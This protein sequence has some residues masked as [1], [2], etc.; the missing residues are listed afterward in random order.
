MAYPFTIYRLDTG[1]IIRTGTCSMY[2]D[3]VAQPISEGEICLD[4]Q[5]NAATQ[6]IV[7]GAA[8]DRPAVVEK[9]FWS[10]PD[11]AES[12][13][14]PVP[15]GT[16]VRYDGGEAVVDD[17]AFEFGSDVPG[18]FLFVIEPPFPYQRQELRVSV[19]EV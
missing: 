7:D 3:V 5:L 12:L 11:E 10:L 9:L 19:R 17:G 18:N 16:V 1:E 2:R 13:S 6:Y 8:A 14:F 15:N 4:V